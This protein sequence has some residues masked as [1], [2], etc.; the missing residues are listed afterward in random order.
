MLTE[1]K[2]E[3][4]WLFKTCDSY[5]D[6]TFALQTIFEHANITAAMMENVQ[7]AKIFSFLLL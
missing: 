2:L 5:N 4:S 7:T 6:L 3:A 1:H